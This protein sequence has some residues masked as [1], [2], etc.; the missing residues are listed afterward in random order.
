MAQRATPPPPDPVA[1]GRK[2]YEREKCAT[3]HQIAKQGNSRYPLD[4]VGSRLSVGDIRRW[5]TETARMEAAL[6]R[7]PPIRM[8]ATQY[9]LKQA[10]LDALVAY[11]ASLK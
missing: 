2:V 8:S 6:P 4:G 3:C 5:M 11:L 10:D 9:K 1:L 7:L